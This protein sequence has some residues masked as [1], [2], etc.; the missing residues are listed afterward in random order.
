MSTTPTTSRARAFFYV[1]LAYVVAFAVACAVVGPARDVF[2]G[3][4]NASLWAAAI[5]DV[6]ATLVI[7]GF[8]FGFRNSSFYDA[9]W[10][11]APPL[12][13]IYFAFAVDGDFVFPPRVVLM[14][15]LVLAYAIRLTHNWARGWSGLHHVDW[16]YVDLKAKSG[17][18]YWLVSLFGI[19]LFPTVQV[20]LGCLPLYVVASSDRPLGWVDVIASVVTGVAILIEL[21]ADNQ[22]RRFVMFR[23]ER[24]ELL[25][26]GLWRYSRHPNYF[27]E[28]LF[29]WGL[30]LFTIPTLATTWWAGAGALSILLMF[31]FVSIPMIEKRS[32]SRRPEYAAHAAK[33]S[34]LIPWRPKG[35]R[36]A[37][38]VAPVPATE[39]GA[40]TSGREPSL[41]LELD[42][43]LEDV[44]TAAPN[45]EEIDEM[46]TDVYS[47]LDVEKAEQVLAGG[48]LRGPSI[49]A[50]FPPLDED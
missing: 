6:A 32:L 43:L 26:S 16:R 44:Q 34:L 28:A 46:E 49:D 7:F 33:T 47:S 30:F 9:Y 41:E 19:H 22:L 27:G 25:R 31:V 5:A 39:E 21:V 37:A 10:S 2:T 50:L 15:A 45:S 4:P 40:A 14:F 8:S 36:P 18:A 3:D 29:W 38:P 13:A 48:S 1:T 12:L 42:D 11:V 35:S 20:F 24:G 17:K 23:V